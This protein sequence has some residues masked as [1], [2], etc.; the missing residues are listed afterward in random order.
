MGDY[1]YFLYIVENQHGSFEADL[2]QLIELCKRLKKENSYL[3]ERESDLLR[4]RSALIE[5][6]DL[7]RSKVEAMI[8]R[9]KGL[10]GES[11]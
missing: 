10:S 3:R 5:K 6:N 11:I 1:H 8:N 2:D 4:E 9:L 7:A